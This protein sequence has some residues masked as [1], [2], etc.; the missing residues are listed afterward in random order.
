M[1][2]TDI[3]ERLRHSGR[4]GPEELDQITETASQAGVEPEDALFTLGLLPEQELAYFLGEAY[5]LPYFRLAQAQV[6]ARAMEVMGLDRMEKHLLAPVSLRPD[7]MTIAIANPAKVPDLSPLVEYFQCPIRLAISPA[8]EIRA[9]LGR[10]RASQEQYRQPQAGSKAKE[11]QAARIAPTGSPEV[12]GPPPSDMDI[13]RALGKMLL[14]ASMGHVS[15]VHLTHSQE[16]IS[17]RCRRDG[18][19]EDRALDLPQRDH[20]RLLELVKR[21]SGMDLAEK[22]QPQTGRMSLPVGLQGTR[23]DLSVRVACIPTGLGERLNIRVLETPERRFG[24]EDLGFERSNLRRLR[25]LLKQPAGG[26]ILTSGPLRSG[27]STTLAAILDEVPAEGKALFSV[28]D[29]IEQKLD[30][31]CQ[32][33]ADPGGHPDTPDLIIAAADQDADVIM[34]SNLQGRE[35]IAT[36]V[37]TAFAGRRLLAGL[38]S[39]D[40]ASSLQLLLHGGADPFKLGFALRG[41]VC[42]RLARTLCCECRKP[43]YRMPEDVVRIKDRLGLTGATLFEPVG[44]QSCDY[45]GFSGRTA[46]QEVLIASPELSHCIQT[47]A[48]L[49]EISRVLEELGNPTLAHDG[50]S[51]ALA[52]ITTVTEVQRVLSM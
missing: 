51:K 3:I 46:I 22:K 50:F 18:V 49:R 41:M 38:V 2:K 30:G 43:I 5:N 39:W 8:S 27:R 1:N 48:P 29:P 36:A 47:A 11:V 28:E 26:L 25:W 19:L 13:M 23:R 12:A 10:T 4:L 15:D 24:L 32:L 17:I 6:P 33:E 40:S 37:D 42:Q 45:R 16:T 14:D 44:C 34:V 31:I 7:G 20:P 52:G 21:L 35:A 9:L